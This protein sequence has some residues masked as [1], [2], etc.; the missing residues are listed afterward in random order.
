MD[1][2]VY[3]AAQQARS[4]GDCTFYKFVWQN[5]A[6]PRVRFFAWLL[7]QGKI[8]CKTNL[9]LKIIIEDA[10]CDLC[11]AEMESPDHLILHCPFAKR[12][13]LQLGFRILA[14]LETQT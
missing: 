13:W 11:T 4:T 7:V 9:L 14:A 2:I 1:A 6:P 10:T 3:R 8:Q 5:R 12:F